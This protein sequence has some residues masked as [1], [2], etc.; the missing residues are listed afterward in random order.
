MY[1]MGA[2]LT[3]AAGE[4]AT[5]YLHQPASLLDVLIALGILALSIVG[6]WRNVPA[7]GNEP[8]MQEFGK[9]LVYSMAGVFFAGALVGIA[10]ETE[11]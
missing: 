8:T 10:G 3:V 4:F 2:W 6:V 5:R 1:G 11:K 7:L 9:S